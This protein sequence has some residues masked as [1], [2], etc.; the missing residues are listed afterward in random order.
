MRR[1]VK[2]RLHHI[3]MVVADVAASSELYCRRFGYT[4]GD[5]PLHDPKQQAMVQF[6]RLTSDSVDLELVSP[7][8]AG[9]PLHAALTQK[10]PLHHICYSTEDI[11]A[12]CRDLQSEGMTLIRSPV[13]AIAF[14]GRR[15]AWLMAKDRL[16]VEVLEA[17]GTA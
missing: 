6:L 16:L 15:V 3:G 2:L 12:A 5:G 7:D 4:P 10:H 17:G 8:S 11:E 9:S 13:E 1:P 14:G